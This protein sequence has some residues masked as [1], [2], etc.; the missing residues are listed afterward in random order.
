MWTSPDWKAHDQID[1]ILIDKRQKSN[2]N[3]VQP[4]MGAECDTDLH[5]VVAKLRGCK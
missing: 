5:L 4:F 2:T 3:D 1:H